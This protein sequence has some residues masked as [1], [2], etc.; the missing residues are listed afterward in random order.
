M[1]ERKKFGKENAGHNVVISGISGRFPS[2]NSFEEFKNNLFNGTDMVTEDD[3]RWPAGKLTNQ[4]Y[5]MQKGVAWDFL[6]IRN[7]S[8]GVQG[9]QKLI[10]MIES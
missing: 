2:S 10:P 7:D 3:S 5:R 8:F 6:V 4:C 9:F 1:K